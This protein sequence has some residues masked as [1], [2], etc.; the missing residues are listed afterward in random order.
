MITI[1]IEKTKVR[2]SGGDESSSLETTIPATIARQ[3]GL[4]PGCG[5]GWSL[6]KVN[7]KWTATIKKE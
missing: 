5:V 1:I 7:G 4:K 6:D 2:K 3:L